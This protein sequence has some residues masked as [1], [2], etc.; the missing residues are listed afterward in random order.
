MYKD[1]LNKQLHAQIL[2]DT[3][4]PTTLAGWQEKA[5]KKQLEYIEVQE[6]LGQKARLNDK[7]ER[8]YKA[9]GITKKPGFYQNK[10]RD[11]QVVPMEVDAVKME[12]LTEEQKQAL[13]TLG[14]CFFCRELG[15]IASKCEKKQKVL[16]QV[17]RA[18]PATPV[19][20]LP[21]Q[22]Q[23]RT[24]EAEEPPQEPPE[25]TRTGLEG[26]TITRE[27]F[28]SLAVELLDEENRAGLVDLMMDF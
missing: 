4:R 18:L 25:Q 15:H 17:R 6:V 23:V 22:G 7:K 28:W 16:G 11:S 9:L 2:R 26:V 20:P 19:R 3:P 13:R 21:Q 10:N 1:G 14:G 27:N 24:T 5:I 8:L 12:P